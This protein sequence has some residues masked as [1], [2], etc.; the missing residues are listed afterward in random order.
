MD[1]LSDIFKNIWFQRALWSVIIILIAIAIYAIIAKFLSAKEKRGSKLVSAKKNRT[2]IR[3]LKSIVGYTLAILTAL[4]ILEVFGINVTSMLAGVGI[5][6]I[7]VGFAL[8][9]ALKDI[10]RGLD[11]ISGSYYDIGDVIKFQDNLGQVQSITLRTTKI[12]DINT[13]NIVSIANR[14]I[15]KV[16]I[17]TGYIYLPVPFPYDIK[18]DKADSIMKEVTKNLAKTDLI[19]SSDYQ[20]LTKIGDSAID[21]QVVLTCDPINR[22]QARRNALHTVVKTLEENKITIPYTQLDIHTK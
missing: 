3:M 13:S 14:N 11:I 16:E 19:T 6:S 17:D 18:T 10:I 1:I 20:G 5:A 2:Y 21:Y 9:D 15:D 4:T 8:Q 12:Q 22:L 7:I